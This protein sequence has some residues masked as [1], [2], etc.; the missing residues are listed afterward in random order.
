MIIDRTGR[1]SVFVQA[2]TRK[3]LGQLEHVCAHYRS[4]P[5]QLSFPFMGQGLHP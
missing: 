4:W 3:R 1:K 2:Y 5:G